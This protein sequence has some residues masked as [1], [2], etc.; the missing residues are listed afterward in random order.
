MFGSYLLISIRGFQ[1]FQP[2]QS[3]CQ[4]ILIQ[5]EGWIFVPV[6]PHHNKS[7]S[8]TTLEEGFLLELHKIHF[9][10][11]EFPSQYPI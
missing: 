6:W 7:H 11:K 2:S 9:K 1:A 10:L 4:A 8:S 5:S 3:S